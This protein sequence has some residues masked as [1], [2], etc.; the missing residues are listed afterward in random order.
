MLELIV[1][2]ILFCSFVSIGNIDI[3]KLAD[4]FMSAGD[5]LYSGR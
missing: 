1:P 3:R 5:H 4:P 2:K